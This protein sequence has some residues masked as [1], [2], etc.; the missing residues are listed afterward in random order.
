MKRWRCE[1]LRWHELPREGPPTSDGRYPDPVIVC[2]RDCDA[3]GV[4]PPAVVR[5]REAELLPFED[6]S[7]SP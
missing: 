6:A 3:W 1:H 5:A 4:R 2:C 7:R